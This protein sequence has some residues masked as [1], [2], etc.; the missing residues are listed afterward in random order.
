MMRMMKMKNGI[1]GLVF[2][3]GLIVAVSEEDPLKCRRDTVKS[4]VGENVTLSCTLRTRLD[5]TYKAFEWKF[6]KSIDVLVYRSRAFNHRDQHEQFKHRAFDNSGNLSE[7]KLSVTISSLTITDFGI[8][9]CSVL[10]VRGGCCEIEL[11]SGKSHS[12][13]ATSLLKKTLL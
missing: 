13:T 9:S 1:T 11:I 8:Y 10:G 4:A 5:V 7:G 2:F 12:V 6:N 3:S